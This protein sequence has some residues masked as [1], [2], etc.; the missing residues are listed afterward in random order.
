MLPEAATFY[1]DKL[2][3]PLA[4]EYKHL[5]LDVI[6]T[7]DGSVPLVAVTVENR[8]GPMRPVPDTVNIERVADPSFTTNRCPPE[9]MAMLT[10]S[11]PWV[12]VEPAAV[13][14]PSELTA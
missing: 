4:V 7:A 9:S 5:P 6:A 11:M 10:G 3:P 12:C 8:A 2:P 1:S 14:V 13:N